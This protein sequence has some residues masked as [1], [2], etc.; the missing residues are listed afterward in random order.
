MDYDIFVPRYSEYSEMVFEDYQYAV[1]IAI[2]VANRLLHD[3][4]ITPQQIIGIGHALYALHRFPISTPGVYVEFGVN[5]DGKDR[6][7]YITYHIT[8]DRFEISTGGY[9]QGDSYSSP[10][11]YIGRSG[12]HENLE[13]FFHAQTEDIVTGWLNNDN[14]KIS[15]N[16]QCDIDGFVEDEIEQNP[17]NY[18]PLNQKAKYLLQKKPNYKRLTSELYIHQLMHFGLQNM[19][20]D[21]RQ[22]RQEIR[23]QHLLQHLEVKV[24]TLRWDMT[25]PEFMSWLLQNKNL[26]ALLETGTLI[27]GATTVLWI[28]INQI[29]IDLSKHIQDTFL[30]PNTALF[31]AST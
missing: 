28:V 17:L 27:E 20:E 1:H 2:N 18:H 22:K 13:P 12:Y 26:S 7:E 23:N 3:S 6:L 21:M 24:K 19:N 10:G 4:R 16:N 25:D 14:T 11:A 15:V 9:T 29:L 5:I 30:T 8:E 31:D